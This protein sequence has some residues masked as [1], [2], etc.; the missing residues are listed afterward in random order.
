MEEEYKKKEESNKT[1]EIKEIIKRWGKSWT[2]NTSLIFADTQQLLLSNIEKKSV[3]TSLIQF[4]ITNLTL[5]LFL[6]ALF[7]SHGFMEDF[8]YRLLEIIF[9]FGIM[10]V[11]SGMVLN[12]MSSEAWVI[13]GNFIF[14]LSVFALG[15]WI[16]VLRWIVYLLLIVA[17]IQGLRLYAISIT[18][19][20]EEQKR[21]F[22]FDLISLRTA[23]EALLTKLQD[24]EDKDDSA[25]LSTVEQDRSENEAERI[26]EIAAGVVLPFMEFLQKAKVFANEN[27]DKEKKPKETRTTGI[28]QSKGIFD[29]SMENINSASKLFWKNHRQFFALLLITF[30]IGVISYTGHVSFGEALVTSFI[31]I[32]IWGV[33]FIFAPDILKMI[34]GLVLGIIFFGIFIIL[35]CI[36]DKTIVAFLG[37]LA[38]VCLLV[39]LVY[40][41]F[42]IPGIF[43]GIATY[44]VIGENFF[45]M[46]LGFI[47]FVIVS[48]IVFFIVRWVL[49]FIIGYCWGYFTGLISN[50]IAV[51]IILGTSFAFN[52]RSLHRI[53]IRSLKSLFDHL[54]IGLKPPTLLGIWIMILSIIFGIR[55]A[56]MFE[57]SKNVV[58]ENKKANK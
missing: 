31:F 58:S 42:L 23:R 21:F 38:I 15:M 10:F 12:K 28:T 4:T 55:I 32:L 22:F 30:I 16:P 27:R 34:L 13:S 39:A 19:N 6:G 50:K 40:A 7:G 3:S 36:T 51:S 48:V 26:G 5:F 37:A 56:M 25:S 24:L 49:P 14:V 29:E 2:N 17:F 11:I 54:I 57:E 1:E 43:L 44:E 47:V 8:L 45:G 18:K 33:V 46:L 52:E 53:S 20:S 35:A 9:L 41:S